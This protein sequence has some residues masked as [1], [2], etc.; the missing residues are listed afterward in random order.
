MNSNEALA[1]YQ[2]ASSNT[3][4][5]ANWDSH[6]NPVTWLH[7]S[8]Q[9]GC[10][11]L[12]ESR[13]RRAGVCRVAIMHSL[14]SYDSHGLKTAFLCG[15]THLHTG[16]YS[17]III[18]FCF[19]LLCPPLH[20]Y[21]GFLEL[22]VLRGNAN[23]SFSYCYFD[24][25]LTSKEKWVSH[26]HFSD[27]SS[28]KP[29]LAFPKWSAYCFNSKSAGKILVDIYKVFWPPRKDK[30]RFIG[31]KI[32]RMKNELPATQ[33]W[34]Q[35]FFTVNEGK[36]DWQDNISCWPPCPLLAARALHQRWPLNTDEILTWLGPASTANAFKH[37]QSV[38]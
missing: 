9:V 13:C 23:W 3:N 8:G 32:Q 18:P 31:D 12:Q 7:C 2:R 1:T 33:K 20:S 27:L 35:N 14:W 36:W 25:L 29:S 4:E 19:I 37:Q 34:W 16:Y 15:C 24:L 28:H 6:L 38:W 17:L 30:L 22:R 11:C 10:F 26:S 5:I 21:K